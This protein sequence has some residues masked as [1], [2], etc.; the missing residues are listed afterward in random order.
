MAIIAGVVAEVVAEVVAAGN[1]QGLVLSS[2]AIEEDLVVD[3]V[4]KAEAVIAVEHGMP[5]SESR[6]SLRY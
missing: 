3:V 6:L 4:V 5:A 1:N 2:L